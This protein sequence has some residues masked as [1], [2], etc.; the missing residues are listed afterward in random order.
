VAYNAVNTTTQV[1]ALLETQYRKRFSLDTSEKLVIAGAFDDATEGLQ[2]LGNAIVLRKIAPK[3]AQTG[4]ATAAMDPTGLTWEQDTEVT[5]TV[6]PTFRYCA[7]SL[8]K[9]AQTRLLADV[10]FK[11]GVREQM[12][13]GL[14]EAIDLSAGDLAASLAT[15]IVGS[16]AV[17]LDQSLILSALSKLRIGAGRYFELGETKAFFDVHPKQVGQLFGITNYMNAQF[18]GQDNGPVATGVVVPGWG[19]TFRITGNV[20]DS[21]GALH[22][23]LHVKESHVI[24]W[25]EKP[26][27]LP[28]QPYGLDL[29]LIAF[30]EAGVA[31]FYDA[32]AVDVQ[33]S[34]A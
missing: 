33:T 5:V 25:N 17:N 24:G 7:Y 34:N 9:P 28:E 12:T 6:S 16:G 4:T 2:K 22:N 10:E 3:A 32:Y 1:A 31:E 13:R 20:D 14:S 21:G 15:N 27:L 19:C 29:L 8:N 30:A 18:R 26:M 23:F 11:R